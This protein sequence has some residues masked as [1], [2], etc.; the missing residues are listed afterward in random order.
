MSS[1]DCQLHAA[2]ALYGALHIIDQADTY[3]VRG[4]ALINKE[5]VK[6]RIEGLAKRY[7]AGRDASATF[8]E[9]VEGRI[10]TPSQQAKAAGLKSLTQV[11]D[12]LGTNKNGH[13]MVSL[14]TLANWHKNKPN[15]FAAVLA[16]CMAIIDLRMDDE[17]LEEE[18]DG[19]G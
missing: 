7:I 5:L 4:E 12:M 2:A 14:Q 9:K 8:G 15:L 3:P 13:P 6:L 18:A 10:I 1:R 19:R 16:G 17:N 11:R